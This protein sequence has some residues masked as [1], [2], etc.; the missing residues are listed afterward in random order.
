M[1]P[2]FGL[3]DGHFTL[4]ALLELTARGTVFQFVGIEL[5]NLHQLKRGMSRLRVTYS[6]AVWTLDE[7]RTLLPVVG[8]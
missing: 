8:I 4:A 5:R 2:L 1:V 3:F 7:H 6:V